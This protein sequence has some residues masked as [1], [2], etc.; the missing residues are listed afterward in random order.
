ME[1]VKSVRLELARLTIAKNSTVTNRVFWHF[2]E[3]SL[4]ADLPRLKIFLGHFPKFCPSASCLVAAKNRRR[5]VVR[6]AK[7]LN[8]AQEA[9]DFT[10]EAAAA[11]AGIISSYAK[12]PLRSCDSLLH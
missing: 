10:K 3:A 12:R 4:E 8:I 11:A 9:R 2:T 6:R 7:L 5:K 1:L